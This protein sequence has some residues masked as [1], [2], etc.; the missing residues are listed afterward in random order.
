MTNWF[1]DSRSAW[2]RRLTGVLRHR[3]AQLVV[4]VMFGALI[5]GGFVAASLGDSS[6]DG[7]TPVHSMFGQHDHGFMDGSG[8]D[9]DHR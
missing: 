7:G 9:E 3:R 4:A 5:G 8:Y 1:A 6:P 2:A